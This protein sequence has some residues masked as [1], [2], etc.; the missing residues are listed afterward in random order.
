MTADWQDNRAERLS[1]AYMLLKGGVFDR[2][3]AVSR[4]VVRMGA[5]NLRAW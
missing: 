4:L 1:N 3:R 5:D 2:F